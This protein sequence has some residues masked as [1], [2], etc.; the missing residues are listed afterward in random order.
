MTP[1]PRDILEVEYRSTARWAHPIR[2]AIEANPSLEERDRKWR[3]TDLSDRAFAIES[4]LTLV[5]QII[6]F[7]DD[8]LVELNEELRRQTPLIRHHGVIRFPNEKPLHQLLWA[9]TAFITESRACFENLAEFYRLF[10][11]TYYDTP[12]GKEAARDVVAKSHQESQW[13]MDLWR[14]RGDLLHKRSLFVAFH[15]DKP[16]LPIFTMNWRPGHFGSADGIELRTLV[17]HL[18]RA[19]WCRLR[20]AGHDRRESCLIGSVIHPHARPG[21]VLWKPFPS[22]RE[23]SVTCDR[24]VTELGARNQR[25]THCPG[26]RFTCHCNSVRAINLSGA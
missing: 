20:D 24:H 13:A 19:L 21:L 5:P 15:A 12:V 11:V 23:F 26:R 25:D 8:T 10:L 1:T 2:H 9:A 7:I 17:A 14:I 18:D 3:A 16:H 6:I 22:H 4:R